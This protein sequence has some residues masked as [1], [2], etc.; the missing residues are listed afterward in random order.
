VAG[1]VAA[2]SDNSLIDELTVSKAVHS[3][4]TTQ[5]QHENVFVEHGGLVTE[6]LTAASGLD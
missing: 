5:Q 3:C 4:H 6:L 2:V 1:T